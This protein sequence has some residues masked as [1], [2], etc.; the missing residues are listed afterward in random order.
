M[1]DLPKPVKKQLWE[2]VSTAHEAALR[3]ALSKL[4]E[5]FERWRHS[6]INS[7]E[8]AER[9]HKFHDGPAREI[10]KQFAYARNADLPILTAFGIATNLIDRRTVPEEIL[11]YL[12]NWVAFL[13]E[14]SLI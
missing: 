1:R 8:L 4:G 11:P 5:D 13:R 2:L 14:R 10:Y 7:F 9:I 12:G 6:E 3:Q